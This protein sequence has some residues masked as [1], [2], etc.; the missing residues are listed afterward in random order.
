MNNDYEDTDDYYDDDEDFVSKTRRK[1]EMHALQDL[2][3]ELITLKVSELDS[4]ELPEDLYDAIRLAQK[5]HQRGA[6]KRQKQ[7]I[8]KLMRDADADTIGE[9]LQQLR[10]KDDL[11]NIHF[12]RLEKWRDS[13]LTEGDDAINT[14]V[15]E[16]PQADRQHL[17]Q[18][19]RKA[20]KE[21]EQNKPPAAARQLFKYLREI[22]D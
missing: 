22:A 18:L 5:L 3:E 14:F 10:H 6:L 11:N 19:Q 17:R 16:F 13:I 4:L 2:G 7:Y 1:K 15:E 12:K 21:A 20:L 9:Q 8:G